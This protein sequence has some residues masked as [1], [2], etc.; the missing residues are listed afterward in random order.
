[1]Q[2]KLAYAL[3]PAPQ[4]PLVFLLTAP[5]FALLAALVLLWTGESALV[6]RWATPTLAITHLLTLGYLSMAMA[7]SMLQLIPVV[8]GTAAVLSRSA[9]ALAWSALSLGTILLSLALGRNL[10]ALFV[11][12]AAALV[13]GFAPL[14][15]CL[16]RALQRPAAPAAMPMVRGMR[17]AV[18]ALVLTLALGCLLASGF[19]GWLVLPLMLLVDLHALWGM[20]GWVLMLVLCVAFQ[21]VPMFQSTR[22]YPVL[23]TRWGTLALGLALLAWSAL[24]VLMPAQTGWASAALT[25]LL[26]GFA[27]CTAW[28]LA[29]PQRK[30]ADA[31]TLYWRLALLSLAL[32]AL[33]VQLPSSDRLTLA[34]AIVFLAGFAMGVVNGMLYKIVPFLLWYHLQQDARARKG[35]VPALR[36]VLADDSA[37]RQFW[38]HCAALGALLAGVWLPALFAR[39]AALLLAA[40]SALLATGLL[41]ATLR[42]RAIQR[43]LQP[44]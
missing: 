20:L 39:P 21:V 3:S 12:A 33:L 10:A 29:R 41:R 44:S 27:A 24:R 15:H 23:V 26:T 32:S 34:T 43:A 17:M 35:T 6:S 37:R 11:P 2:R 38:C 36:D 1:M 30:K 7:G 18:A 4:L 40:A 14:L 5:W 8:T 22:L 42:C 28:L 13:V 9:A 31:S 19:G 16:A 25:L